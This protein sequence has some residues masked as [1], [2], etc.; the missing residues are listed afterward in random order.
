MTS[1]F[2]AGRGIFFWAESSVIRNVGTRV[3]NKLFM[4][5]SPRNEGLMIRLKGKERK[6][7]TCGRVPSTPRVSRLVALCFRIYSA[8][9]L[10]GE[11]GGGLGHSFLYLV[12]FSLFS[13]CLQLFEVFFLFGHT[14]N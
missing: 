2:D 7:L 8:C 14:C 3:G 11:G 5:R 4:T 13:R 12:V 9:F 6:G 1:Y 10:L